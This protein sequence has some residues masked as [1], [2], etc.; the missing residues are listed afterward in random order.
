LVTARQVLVR[1]QK[2][3]ESVPRVAEYSADEIARA[4]ELAGKAD[5]ALDGEESEW[6]LKL[7]MILAAKAEVNA[8]R[9]AK[10]M[11]Q[12]LLPYVNNDS[13]AHVQTQQDVDAA[14]V[15]HVAQYEKARQLNERFTQLVSSYSKIMSLLSLKFAYWQQQ[16]QQDSSR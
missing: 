3:S 11:M 10:E 12:Q 8:L 4:V 16:L 15:T 13:T 9:K 7:E 14:K 5:S 2:L 1:W 6:K